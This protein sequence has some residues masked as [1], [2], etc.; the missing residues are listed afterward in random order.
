MRILRY[1]FFDTVAEF[2]NN[3]VCVCAA[4]RVVHRTDLI[5]GLFI[6]PVVDAE[7]DGYKIDIGKIVAVNNRAEGRTR[8]ES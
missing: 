5:Y 8:H 3:L 1:D 4:Y 2:G 6:F 7:H